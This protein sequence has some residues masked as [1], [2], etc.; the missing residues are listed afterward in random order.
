MAVVL[1]ITTNEEQTVELPLLEKCII[2]RSSHSDFVIADKQMS[3]KHGIFELND[4]GE[5][6]YT[7][8]GSTNGSYLNSSQI[9]KIQFRINETLRLGNTVI[10]IDEKRLNSRERL[11]I[12]KGLIESNAKVDIPPFS[13]TKSQKFNNKNST[14]KIPEK[15]KMVKLDVNKYKKK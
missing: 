3:G 12:G 4:N 11:A 1:F 9:H 15:S 6:F 8:L 5:L 14:K 7:D 2:G 13:G 10:T